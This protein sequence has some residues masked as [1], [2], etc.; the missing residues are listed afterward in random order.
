MPIVHTMPFMQ[1]TQCQ[2]CTQCHLSCNTMPNM[3]T[4]P[5]M[6]VI[7]CQMCQQ[8]H[9]CNRHNANNA[10]NAIFEHNAIFSWHPMPI[11]HPMPNVQ[12]IWH[13][14]LHI[15]HWIAA[16]LALTD[17][18]LSWHMIV[19]GC[20]QVEQNLFSSRKYVITKVFV[21]V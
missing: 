7:Q 21:R 20:L 4:M 12:H 1:F 17:S 10:H 3:H 5:F 8:C 16:Y 2:L 19:Y 13:W 15:W 9:L 6:Q 18:K 14:M 11:V